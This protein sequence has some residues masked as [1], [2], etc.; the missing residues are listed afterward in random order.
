MKRGMAVQQVFIYM[1]AGIS[2]AFILIF[3]VNMVNDLMEKG[4]MV[5]FMQFKTNLENNVKKIYS[6]YGAARTLDFSL[7]VKYT[8]ICFVDMDA[9]YDES[10]C[11][12]SAIAC[13]A[14]ETAGSWDAADQNVFLDPPAAAAIK[15]YK[16]RMDDGYLCLPLENGRFTLRLEGRGDAAYLSQLVYE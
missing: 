9:T 11:A 4:E 3:G 6:D 12:K 7:P 1:I 14:W 10:L 2:F 8:E 16:L 5:E 15:T 13:D